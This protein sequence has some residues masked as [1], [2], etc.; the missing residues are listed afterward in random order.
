MHANKKYIREYHIKNW[1]LD[2]ASKNQTK[3]YKYSTN[4]GLKRPRFWG[5][6]GGAILGPSTTHKIM[7]L[8]IQVG[9]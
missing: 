3:L 4:L 1:A 5:L 7:K 6:F 9:M 2:H 8:N